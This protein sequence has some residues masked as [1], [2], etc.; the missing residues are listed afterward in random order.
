MSQLA[1]RATMRN[2]TRSRKPKTQ[3]EKAEFSA[4]VDGPSRLTGHRIRA[5]RLER[6]WTLHDLGRRLGLSPATISSLENGH[7]SI[8][9][10]RLVHIAG[11][12]DVSPTD[13]LVIAV[14]DNGNKRDRSAAAYADPPHW[15]HFPPLTT[16]PVVASAI[17]TFVHTG[18]HGTNM[19]TIAET[20]GMS[21]AGVYHHYDSKQD[22]LNAVLD[23]TMN[24]LEW[25]L[26]AARDE[27]RSSG[28]GP[29]HRLAALVEALALFHTLRPH[30]AFIGASEMRSL[31]AD[32]RASIV[33]R[34]SAIQHLIDE[35]IAAA[36]AEGLISVERP[37]E[38]GRAISTMCTSLPQWFDNTGPTTPEQ[39]A[40]E[41]AALA[42]RMAGVQQLPH[43]QPKGLP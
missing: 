18:F 29:L 23:L 40:C 3:F 21:I 34:R 42:L 20:A 22:I 12:L 33:R 39:I 26:P 43:P 37:R 11:V 16:D 35:E 25:R 17:R 6:R 36:C 14:S 15:R 9:I 13:L 4:V 28:G 32:R 19:R 27:A 31:R 30:L 10:D 2:A 1:F 8:T 38:I 24:E 5:L 7:T 41:Y